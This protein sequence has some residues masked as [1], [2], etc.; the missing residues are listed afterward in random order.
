MGQWHH[1]GILVSSRDVG[2]VAL[3]AQDKLPDMQMQMD[4]Q[5]QCIDKPSIDCTGPCQAFVEAQQRS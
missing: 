4:M 2:V 3:H 5:R 1:K